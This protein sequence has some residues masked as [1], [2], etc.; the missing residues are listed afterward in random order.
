M[1]LREHD[2]LGGL[3]VGGE[4]PPVDV[5]A[6]AQVGVVRVL[7]GEREHVLHHLL[8][9]GGALEEELDGGG[10]ELQLHQRR[11]VVERVQD[12]LQQLSLSASYTSSLSDKK[13]RRP[14]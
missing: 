10:E 1:L 2:L 12:R 5:A 14:P 9:V 7:R 4:E 13:N 8:R 6:V 11:L 3:R